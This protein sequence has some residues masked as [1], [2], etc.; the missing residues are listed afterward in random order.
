MPVTPMQQH[1]ITVIFCHM[2]VVDWTIFF[3]FINKHFFD[4]EKFQYWK[5]FRKGYLYISMNQYSL[6]S[7]VAT[8]RNG[9]CC[10]STANTTDSHIKTICRRNPRAANHLRLRLPVID[11]VFLSN[12]HSKE[13]FWFLKLKTKWLSWLERLY[14]KG[15]HSFL[16]NDMSWILHEA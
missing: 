14:F 11:T 7:P 12:S 13:G 2:Y 8:L 9:I 5:L 4:T 16:C 3:L 6:T 1:V 15:T 10:T